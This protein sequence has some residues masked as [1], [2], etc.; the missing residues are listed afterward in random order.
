MLD[1]SLWNW[2]DKLETRHLKQLYQVV[3][4]LR[5]AAEKRPEFWTK[6]LDSVAPVKILLSMVIDVFM[7]KDKSIQMSA[8]AIQPDIDTLHVDRQSRAHIPSMIHTKTP[9]PPTPMLYFQP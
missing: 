7:L 2:W 9:C 3:K 5:K 1:F 6:T 4:D 8:A